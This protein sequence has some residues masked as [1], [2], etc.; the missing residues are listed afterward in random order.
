MKR[1]RLLLLL[2][3]ALLGTGAAQA[4]RGGIGFGGRP[5]FGHPG[6]IGGWK[7]GGRFGGYANRFGFP[8]LPYWYNDVYAGGWY[9]DVYA[10]PATAEAP[11]MV[12]I[13][14]EPRAPE[15]ALSTPAPKPQIIEVPGSERGPMQPPPAVTFVLNNGKRIKLQRYTLTSDYLFFT[16]AGRPQRIARPELN[17]DATVAANRE[18]GIPFV[19]PSEQNEISLGF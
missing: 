12:V 1:L 18:R 10:G 9:N 7:V 11:P 6:V 16:A 15:P 3:V 5:G 8:F 17:A 13:E 2:S 19:F 4:Q 14:R